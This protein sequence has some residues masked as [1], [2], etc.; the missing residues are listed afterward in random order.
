MTPHLLDALIAFRTA[1]HNLCAAWETARQ[2]EEGPDPLEQAYPFQGAFFDVCCAIDAWID[3]AKWGADRPPLDILRAI[4]QGRYKIQLAYPPH[5]LPSDSQEVK[6][7]WRRQKIAYQIEDSRLTD[8][9][10]RDAFEAVGLTDHPK[11]NL[12]YRMAW[13][14]GHKEG[15][16]GIFDHLERFAQ[17]VK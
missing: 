16:E 8:L 10:K 5:P 4:K 14:N 7:E 9:F 11:A 13:E 12:A 17:M 2:V 3:R 1:S 15:L 6:D